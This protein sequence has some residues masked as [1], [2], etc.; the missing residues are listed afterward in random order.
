MNAYIFP[1]INKAARI[2]YMK[3]RGRSKLVKISDY[4]ICEEI[5]PYIDFICTEKNISI[6]DLLSKSRKRELVEC[7]YWVFYFY[8][9]TCRDNN[10]EPLTLEMIGSSIKRDHATVLHGIRT[11][12]NLLT[13]DL[14]KGIELKQ[15]YEDFL[16]QYG[17]D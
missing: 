2:N 8:T 17:N 13:W 10:I 4:S 7:R 5:T 12:E 14:K 15:L 6:L 9:K 11:M 1:V 16:K 3:W